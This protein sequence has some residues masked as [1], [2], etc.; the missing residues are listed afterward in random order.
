MM[1]DIVVKAT[2][3]CSI[4]QD[5]YP[6][7]W[8]FLRTAVLPHHFKLCTKHQACN[9]LSS[10]TATHAHL[11]LLIFRTQ[12]CTYKND[13][14]LKA[15]SAS[16]EQKENT[17]EYRLWHSQ[18]WLVK[19]SCL[20]RITVCMTRAYFA[21]FSSASACDVQLV[22]KCPSLCHW[23]VWSYTAI[24]TMCSKSLILCLIKFTTKPV[25]ATQRAR[26]LLDWWDELHSIICIVFMLTCKYSNWFADNWLG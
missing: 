4:G 14:V 10:F 25:H 19:D 12:S 16:I 5:Q 24:R 23:K 26:P 8:P 15:N 18:T 11:V 22:A 20:S 21:L 9:E 3:G 7:Y 1:D 17:K 2:N 6:D 13:E